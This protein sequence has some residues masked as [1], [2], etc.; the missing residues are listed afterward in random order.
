VGATIEVAVGFYPMTDYLDPAVLAG[1]CEGVNRALETVE[2]ARSL[3]GHAYLK[4]FI[5]ERVMNSIRNGL[6]MQETEIAREPS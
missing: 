4:S 2:G 5:V 3:A 6:G 1:R